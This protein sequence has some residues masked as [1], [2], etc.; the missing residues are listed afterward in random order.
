MEIGV[1][2]WLLL[3]EFCH[4]IG[5]PQVILSWSLNNQPLTKYRRWFFC[6]F[7]ESAHGQ[8]VK[9]KLMV[10][11]SKAYTRLSNSRGSIYH[12]DTGV[13]QCS[14]SLRLSLWVNCA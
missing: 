4:R 14:I 7:P 12:P 1:A 9:H 13:W 8:R 3:S 10:E 11:L 2:N 6:V 5:S